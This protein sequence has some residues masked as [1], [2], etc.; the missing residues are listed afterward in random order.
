MAEAAVCQE[1]R[2]R[3]ESPLYEQIVR[4]TGVVKSL[5]EAVCSERAACWYVISAD[6]APWLGVVNASEVVELGVEGS[7]C[8]HHNY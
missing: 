6:E 5:L 7:L 8:F 4:I 1:M 2:R 3:W